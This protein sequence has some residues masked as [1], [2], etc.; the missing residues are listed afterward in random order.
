VGKNLIMDNLNPSKIK[1]ICDLGIGDVFMF[2]NRP[3][4]VFCNDGVFF[5]IRSHAY[6]GS[7]PSSFTINIGVESIQKVEFLFNEKDSCG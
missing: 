6:L 7:K 3:R 5:T 4:V 2:H 1:R